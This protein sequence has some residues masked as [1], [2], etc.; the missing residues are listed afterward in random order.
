MSNALA[1][2]PEILE[3]DKFDQKFLDIVK[4]ILLELR[5]Q[6]PFMGILASEMWIAGPTNNPQIQTCAVSSKGVVVYNESFMKSITMGEVIGV[7]LHESLHVAL[8]Y[9]DRFKGRKWELANVAHDYAINDIIIKGQGNMILTRKNGQQFNFRVSLPE[10]A[11][12]D[13]KFDMLSG[14]EIYNLLDEEIKARAKEMMGQVNAA[15]QDPASQADRERQQKIDEQL[16]ES[17]AEGINVIDDKVEKA[18][19][20]LQGLPM[21]AAEKREEERQTVSD[22]LRDLKGLSLSMNG[23]AGESQPED[24]DQ[25]EQADNDGQQGEP[26][27]DGQASPSDQQASAPAQSEGT[28]PSTASA[29][30]RQGQPDP[31]EKAK[32][33]MTEGML[34]SLNDYMGKERE[35]IEGEVDN[36]PNGTTR[37]Q[38]LDE[39]SNNLDKAADDYRNDVQNA[40]NQQENQAGEP[41]QEPGQEPGD[42]Q[43]GQEQQGQGQPGQGQ[44]GQGEPGQGQSGQGQQ[45]QGQQ[46]QG[47]PGQGQPGQG[48]AGQGQQGQAGAEAP[49]RRGVQSN[50]TKSLDQLAKQAEQA[51]RGENSPVGGYTPAKE[52]VDGKALEE[53]MR[54]VM[55]ERGVGPYQGDIHLDCTDIPGNPFAQETPQQTKTRKMQTLQRAVVEDTKMGSKG[56]GSLPSW[57]Q[58]EISGILNP[59]LSFD[60]RMRKFIG[61]FGRPDA[62]TFKRRNKRNTF[63][64]NR[65]IFPG[66]KRNKAKVYMLLDTSGSM[67]NGTDLDTLR[68]SMGL[69]KRLS[70]S[71]GLEVAVVQCDAEVTKVMNTREAMEEIRKNRFK[72]T[73]QGGSDFRP[74]FEMIWKQMKENDFGFGSPIIV[75]TDGGISV[76][77]QIPKNLPMQVM[78]V[79]NPGQR[80]PT[81]AYGEHLVMTAS[82]IEDG[83]GR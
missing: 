31:Y 50:V 68:R 66:S 1:I 56:W 37:Q 29:P 40:K 76:P 73:G 25:A 24:N 80:A 57:A 82:T 14:E 39:L 21:S 77:D 18:I 28:Q 12:W 44:S 13:K 51:M 61:A 7:L 75:F 30:G 36:Q 55:E 59:P 83:P 20:N 53:A 6:S 9:W 32:S 81:N 8:D 22:A 2:K 17:L 71:L 47:E 43:P 78:W 16:R 72:I 19:R 65:A 34:D 49:S 41:G 48:Q 54:Q 38:H 3:A 27:A 60:K 10:G 70:N 74:G 63:Q 11:L 26:G 4:L 58:T 67:M 33:E 69:V 52:M 5:T 45:G 46:G 35:R 23:T 42:G 64:E 62:R 79:T 15:M